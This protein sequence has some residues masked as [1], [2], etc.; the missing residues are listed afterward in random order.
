[1]VMRHDPNWALTVTRCD[2]DIE[3]ASRAVTL[4]GNRYQVP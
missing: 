2:P 1:M 3:F 4:A